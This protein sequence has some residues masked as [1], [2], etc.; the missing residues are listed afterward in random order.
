MA[1]CLRITLGDGFTFAKLKSLDRGPGGLMRAEGFRPGGMGTAES[2][3][4]MQNG[5]LWL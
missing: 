3:L 2:V 4:R 1:A 5:K